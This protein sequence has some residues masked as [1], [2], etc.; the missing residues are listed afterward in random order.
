[1]ILQLSCKMF[2]HFLRGLYEGKWD[3]VISEIEAQDMK[4]ISGAAI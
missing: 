4:N 2:N 1:M 3:V